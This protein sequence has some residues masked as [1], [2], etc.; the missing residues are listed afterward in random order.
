MVQLNKE[1]MGKGEKTWYK[2]RLVLK[3]GGRA[4]KGYF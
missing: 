1:V 3:I 2:E 4:K